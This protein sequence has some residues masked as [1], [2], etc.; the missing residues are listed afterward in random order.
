MTCSGPAGAF[1]R[2][3]MSIGGARGVPEA[4]IPPIGANSIRDLLDVFR[5]SQL[6]KRLLN[7][8]IHE[9]STTRVQQSILILPRS[10]C[11]PKWPKLFETAKKNLNLIHACT[12]PFAR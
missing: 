12:C 10:S 8:L 6:P 7:Y 4:L 11:R 9:A 3:A 5:A 1:G 2:S